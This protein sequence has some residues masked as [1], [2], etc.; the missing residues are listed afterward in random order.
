[1]QVE[2]GWSAVVHD[3][4]NKTKQIISHVNSPIPKPHKTSGLTLAYV[5]PWNSFGYDQAKDLNNKIDI[6]SPV[7]LNFETPTDYNGDHDIDRDWMNTGG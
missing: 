3:G 2:L 5:T 4:T 1:M 7:W 6:V